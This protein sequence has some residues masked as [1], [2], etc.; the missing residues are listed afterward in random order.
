[1]PLAFDGRIWDT[2]RGIQTDIAGVHRF[3]I[4]EEDLITV[5]GKAASYGGG[6][7]AAHEGGHA[8]QASSL[9]PAQ[10]ATLTSLY[11][12]RLAA[13]GP[14]TPTTPASDQTA[15]WLNPAW[16]S[17]ANKEEY[18][19]NSVAAYLGHPYSNN[20]ADQLMYNRSWLQ[21]ND[22]GMSALLQ[23]IYAH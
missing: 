7:L 16:Y 15:M 17:A 5:P 2:V 10:I 19:A 8:L 1:M 20:D 18:F 6:F 12:S 21:T 9:T 3:A 11:T 22:P 13:S 23:T 4:A 14:I